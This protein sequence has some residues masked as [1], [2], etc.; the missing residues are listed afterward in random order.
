MQ[1]NGFRRSNSD[2]FAQ[3][4]EHGMVT[5]SEPLA[6]K[7]VGCEES[8]SSRTLHLA[9]FDGEDLLEPDAVFKLPKPLLA[10]SIP[11]AT[12]QQQ[13]P[14]DDEADTDSDH[15]SMISVQESL[16]SNGSLEVDALLA[17]G[18]VGLGSARVAVTL[19]QQVNLADQ[20]QED[21]CLNKEVH[22][23]LVHTPPG[24]R[25][26]VQE[27]K[28]SAL[29]WPASL[30][31]YLRRQGVTEARALQATMWP[32]VSKLQSILV[33]APPSTRSPV[34]SW[35]EGKT[36]GWL[37]PMLAILAEP[38]ATNLS[39]PQPR[40][41]V[42]CP[43]LELVSLTAALINQVAVG[44]GI[45]LKLVEDAAGLREVEASTF[46]NG[47]DALVTTPARLV[48]RME[49]QTPVTGLHR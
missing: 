36:L 24:S 15:E 7:L 8:L 19:Q 4:R 26:L 42:L 41:V 28:V 23:H 34:S 16:R 37:L 6:E 14:D 44:A 21:D 1:M 11:R 13:P 29:P 25:A 31:A 45:P 12:K 43:G 40:L 5:T 32:A 49:E 27:S 47:I 48:D 46:I 39:G 10:S 35:A 17:T 3:T 30:Q 20:H 33:I 2:N 18:N 38:P 9:G 22:S